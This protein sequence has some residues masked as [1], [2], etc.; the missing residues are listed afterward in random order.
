VLRSGWGEP[1]EAAVWLVGDRWY[2]DHRNAGEHGMVSLYAHAAP[3]ALNWGPMYSPYAPSALLRNTLLPAGSDWKAL[4]VP[5]EGGPGDWSASALDAFTPDAD[6]GMAQ[7]TARGFSSQWTRTVHLRQAGEDW[8]VFL[9]DDQFTQVP[10]VLSLAMAAED[11]VQT[12]EGDRKPGE[13]FT[14]PAGVSRLDFTGQPLERHPAGGID[15]SLFVIADAPQEAFL[16][17]WSHRNRGGQR[18]V[19]LRL[20]GESRF[21]VV[22]VPWPK[23]RQP[24][25]VVVHRQEDGLAV[26]VD[27]RTIRFE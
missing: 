3:L 26:E 22:V 24:Q 15:W 9:I 6:G 18:Q 5:H 13:C 23:G 8:P 25:V 7:C 10:L 11:D 20:K 19:I 4:P 12:P 14:L 16:T 2:R 21:Q 27:G 17:E 1:H